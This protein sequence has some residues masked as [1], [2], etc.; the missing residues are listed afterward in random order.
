MQNFQEAVRRLL[1]LQAAHA[2]PADAKLSQVEK[3][4]IEVMP[5]NAPQPADH[6]V[7]VGKFLQAGRFWEVA[8][9][10]NGEFVR[11]RKSR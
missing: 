10:L 1:G 9:D 5:E 8:I 11:I 7:W 4:W 3:R 6:L 2:I